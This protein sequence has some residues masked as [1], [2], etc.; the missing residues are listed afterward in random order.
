MNKTENKKF[1]AV[2][3][4]DF[5]IAVDALKN[6]TL[7]LKQLNSDG[8]QCDYCT[9]SKIGLAVDE[10]ISLSKNIDKVWYQKT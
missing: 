9:D 5:R 8:E 4:E 6:A 2:L 1:K 10:I 7:I 3:A